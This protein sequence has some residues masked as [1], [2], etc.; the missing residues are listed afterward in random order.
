MTQPR[1]RRK[2]NRAELP[3]PDQATVRPKPDM[4]R[5][6]PTP[7]KGTWGEVFRGL[8]YFSLAA[9]GIGIVQKLTR[10]RSTARIEIIPLDRR[11]KP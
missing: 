8:G 3:A 1:S 10:P 4:D 7:D 6:T 11:I 9:F 5:F 2:K